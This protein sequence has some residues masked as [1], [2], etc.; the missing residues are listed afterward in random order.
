MAPSLALTGAPQYVELTD[1]TAKQAVQEQARKSKATQTVKAGYLV[2]QSAVRGVWK[3]R[4]V[5]LKPGSLV[6]YQ[7]RPGV[8]EDAVPQVVM[9]LGAAELV[10][11][12]KASA[13]T[14]RKHAFG[15][16]LVVKRPT[17]FHADSDASAEEWLTALAKYSEAEA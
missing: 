8:G 11:V 2:R 7:C 10:G 6:V 17:F 1:D 16:A 12:D 15:V 3:T 5:E 14:A 4:W 9:P 13:A